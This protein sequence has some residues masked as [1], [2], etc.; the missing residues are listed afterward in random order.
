MDI[1]AYQIRALITPRRNR[2][3]F[4]FQGISSI[5]HV[6]KGRLRSLR[7]PT[8]CL[9]TSGLLHACLTR[10]CRAIPTR[11]RGLLI[12]TVIPILTF[13]GTQLKSIRQRLPTIKDASGLYGATTIIRVRLR[14]V[15]RPFFERM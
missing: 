5:I 10:L 7:P 2:R 8:T 15:T 12:L 3:I 4:H 11:R 6:T 13:H 14:K 9:R 1:Q